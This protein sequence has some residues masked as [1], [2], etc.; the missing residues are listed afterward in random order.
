M[1]RQ[2]LGPIDLQVLPYGVRIDHH[3]VRL[4]LHPAGHVLGSAQVRLEHK[5]RV[6]VASGDYFVAGPVDDPREGNA[7]CAPFEPVRCDCF[8]TESTFGLPIYRW[9]PQR[10]LFADIDRWW[11]ANAEAGRPSLLMG[12][13][14]GKAQRILA[15]VDASIGPIVVHGAVEPLNRAYRAAGVALPE[16]R[17]ATEVTDKASFKRALIVAPPSVQNSVWTRALRRPQR[18]FRE[19]LDAVARG[20]PAALGRPRFRAQRPRRLARAAAC[21]RR[22]RRG[23]GDRDPRLRKRDGAMADRAGPRGGRVLD[24][25]RRRP[26]G[27]GRGPGNRARRRGRGPGGMRAF[28]TL[29]EELDASTATSAKVEALK[30]YFRA[31]PPVDAAWAVYFLAGGRPRQVV[32][33]AL[34]RALACERAR[35]EPWL[36][37]E[38]YQA[39]GDLAETIAHVLPPASTQVDLGL[40]T[41]VEQRLLPLRAVEPLEQARRIAAYWD[42]LDTPGRF[43]LT[44]LIGGGFRVGVSKLLV[45]R[46]LA[47]VAGIDPKRV[48]QRMMGYTDARQAPDAAHYVALTAIGADEPADAGPALSVLPGAPA[49]HAGRRLRREVG[50]RPRTGWSNGNTTASGPRWSSAPARSG[51]GRARE[52]ADDRALPGDRRGGQ[53]IARR[54]RAGRR[55]RGLEGRRPRRLSH[56]CSNASAAR[57]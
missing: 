27:P 20:A 28:A 30:R 46:A 53:R 54:Q 19:R 5:G 49:R 4:S 42:E 32:P 7:T 52:E 9:A 38:A 44:K 1:L 45:Q 11:A 23:A 35:I 37:E 13:S 26:G 10:T 29:F 18:C 25:V 21:H 33:T 15:G 31:A 50:P 55:D 36:F 8:I 56:C 39:V 6:W 14:F 51:S 17:L 16:T 34:L 57:T 12:Y 41:W 48:A 47:E 43:L 24:R 3:G 2:R 22:D 40:A